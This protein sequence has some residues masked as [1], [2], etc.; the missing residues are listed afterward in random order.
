MPALGVDV[1]GQRKRI[2]LD[3]PSTFPCLAISDLDK[4]SWLQRC[5]HF[6]Q[7]RHKGEESLKLI[8]AGHKYHNRD[9]ERC[10]ILL[11]RKVL[12]NGDEGVELR[13]SQRQQPAVL[14]PTPT[15]FNSGFYNVRGQRPAKTAGDRFVKQQ[16]HEQRD[17]PSPLRALQLPLH[18]KP[19]ESLQGSPPERS[20]LPDN[21]TEIEPARVFP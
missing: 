20:F 19:R 16:A 1:D 4:R 12:I 7:T 13:S 15:H 2:R 14:H 11:I 9:G 8:G 21:Q 18:E 5:K 6:L 17:A 3:N 10:N